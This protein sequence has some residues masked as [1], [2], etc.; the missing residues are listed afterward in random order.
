MSVGIIDLAGGR[1]G[2]GTLAYFCVVREK[3]YLAA[4]VCVSVYLSGSMFVEWGGEQ[5]KQWKYICLSPPLWLCKSGDIVTVLTICY[6]E[7][8]FLPLILAVPVRQRD[9]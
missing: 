5:C 4:N 9:R 7:I 6:V 1:M 3:F 8:T 2:G